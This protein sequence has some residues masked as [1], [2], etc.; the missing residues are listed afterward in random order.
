[1][2]EISLVRYA[3]EHAVYT[4]PIRGSV[5]LADGTVVHVGPDVIEV[6]SPGQGAEVAHLIGERHQAEGHPDFDVEDHDF[7]HEPAEAF[8]DYVPH[9]EMARRLDKA[10]QLDPGLAERVAAQ[11]A[12][13]AQAHAVGGDP[14]MAQLTA[15]RALKED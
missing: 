4:G 11:R 14:A 9:P 5:T 1:M 8:A 12:A 15:A 7:V 3:F 6:A 10:R 2:S 13:R